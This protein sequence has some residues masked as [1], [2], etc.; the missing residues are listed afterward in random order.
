MSRNHVYIVESNCKHHRLLFHI[1]FHMVSTFSVKAIGWWFGNSP[2]Q[3]VVDYLTR[4]IHDSGT[5]W[6]AIRCQRGF[7]K[8]WST[9]PSH[10]PN[11]RGRNCPLSAM[12]VKVFLVCSNSTVFLRMGIFSQI[13]WNYQL[14][15]SERLIHAQLAWITTDSDNGLVSSLCQVIGWTNLIYNQLH[16]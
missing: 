15:Q 10:R 6:C 14:D 3:S 7:Y 16:P 1:C 4:S 11:P 9:R 8:I 5:L 2:D 12:G 13:S